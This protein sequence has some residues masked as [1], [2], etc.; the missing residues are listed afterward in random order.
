MRIVQSYSHLNGEE[1][2][3]VHHPSAYQ[4]IKDVIASVNAFACQTKRSRE[5]TM[6]NK[7]LFAPKVLNKEFKPNLF[8]WKETTDWGLIGGI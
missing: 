5:K 3:L 6:H 4:E 2:L 7:V 1:Y 8:D